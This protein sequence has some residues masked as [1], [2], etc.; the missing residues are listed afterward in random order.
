M[1]TPGQDKAGGV[2]GGG[3]GGVQG[4]QEAEHNSWM[5]HLHEQE[6][7]T[8]K[9]FNNHFSM[10]TVCSIQAGAWIPE[11]WGQGLKNMLYKLSTQKSPALEAGP[12]YLTSAHPANLDL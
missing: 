6:I 4:Q 10:P 1:W 8:L 9:F 3:R 7:S 12:A 5:T 11:V 2:C